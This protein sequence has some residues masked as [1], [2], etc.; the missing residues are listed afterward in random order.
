MKTTY[1]LVAFGILLNFNCKS[2]TS[3]TAGT[4]Y[5]E[6]TIAE[7]QNKIENETLI[8]FN[9]MNISE[10]IATQ[11]DSVEGFLKKNQDEFSFDNEFVP[12]TFSGRTYIPNAGLPDYRDDLSKLLGLIV[13]KENLEYTVG[14]VPFVKDKSEL[15]VSVPKNGVLVERKVE[16][17]DEKKLG[18]I[19]SVELDDS[20]ILNYTIEDLSR[21]ILDFE[22]MDVE[23]LQAV[24]N[25]SNWND[26]FIIV[27]A[28][29]TAITHKT[30]RKKGRRIRF[31]EIPLI[32]SAISANSNIYISNES[33]Q[34][35][36]RVGLRLV[37]IKSIIEEITI[38]MN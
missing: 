34:R 7:I 26:R 15:K 1:I 27:L 18:W 9:G 14:V 11:L 22:Q 19:L 31:D 8:K 28:T 37:S 21:A 10:E 24:F 2:P 12:S 16:K 30:H 36:F 33:L 23:K 20:E 17:K 35:D 25:E 29:A 38:G 6:G 13:T 3:E 32:G 4:E 5:Q